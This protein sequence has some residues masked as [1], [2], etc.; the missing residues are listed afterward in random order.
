[1]IEP[2][3]GSPGVTFRAIFFRLWTDGRTRD[4]NISFTILPEDRLLAAEL[5]KD[6]DKHGQVA[7]V[8]FPESE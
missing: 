8:P 4:T 3:K 6:L 5:L 7:W 1:M 2:K